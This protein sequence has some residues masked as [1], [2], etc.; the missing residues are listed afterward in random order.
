MNLF[1]ARSGV[2]SRRAAN[3]LIASGA[4]LVNGSRPPPQGLLIDPERDRVTVAG[5]EVRPPSAHAYL[6]LNKPAGHLVTARDPQ[7]RPTAL[8]LV[9][10][11]SRLFSV[12]RL[13][14]DTRG[15][16]LLTDDGGLAHRLAHPRYGVEKEYVATVEGR[17]SREALQRLRDGVDL[18]DGRTQPARVELLA[19]NRVRLRIHEG[20]KRQVRRMLAAVGHPV[21][22]LVRTAFGPLRAEDLPEGRHRELTQEELKELRSAARLT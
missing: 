7:G 17:P 2:A 18:E 16:L 20:R 13:D 6:V 22:D 19:P 1:L 15:V 21:T 5:R 12:G 4:V 3:S 14:R 8:D 10:S 9:A 11:G